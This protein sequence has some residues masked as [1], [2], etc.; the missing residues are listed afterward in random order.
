MYSHNLAADKLLGGIVPASVTTLQSTYYANKPLRLPHRQSVDPVSPPCSYP[1]AMWSLWTTTATS[2]VVRDISITKLPNWLSSGLTNIPFGDLIGS[3][4]IRGL[5]VPTWPVVG[6]VFI[7]VRF[8]LLSLERCLSFPS[9]LSK[10]NLFLHA[11]ET[12]D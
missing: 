4:V 7:S 10:H 11:G 9:S 2:T 3:S 5:Q 1:S 8:S 6:G 12:H